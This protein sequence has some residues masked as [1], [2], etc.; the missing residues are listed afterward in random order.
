MLETE[1]LKVDV[2]E[3]DGEKFVI[4]PDDV[5]EQCG[6]NDVVDMS[7]ENDCIFL[8]AIDSN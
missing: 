1:H 6:V 4:L 2:I 7:V 5:L 8:K 3:K